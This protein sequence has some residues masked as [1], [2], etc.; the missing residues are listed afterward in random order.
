MRNVY[1]K[2]AFGNLGVRYD[3]KGNFDLRGLERGIEEVGE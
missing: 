3:F 2:E 1:I